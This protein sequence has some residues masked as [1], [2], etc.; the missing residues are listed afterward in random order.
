MEYKIHKKI[1]A[2]FN[3]HIY[4][5]FFLGALLALCSMIP[6]V[7]PIFPGSSLIGVF[8]LIIGILLVVPV[9][10]VRHVI[11]LRKWLIY[12]FKNIHRKRIIKHKMSDISLHIKQILN[13]ERPKIFGQFHLKKNFKNKLNSK[14]H[15][16]SKKKIIK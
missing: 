12:M 10:K 7:L 13:E 9:T 14:V 4:I 8:I 16:I 3:V 5:R 11:K 15:N 2:Y 1:R 6:I